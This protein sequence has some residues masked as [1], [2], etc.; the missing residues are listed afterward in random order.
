[1][2]FVAVESKRFPQND[3]DW[4]V[5]PAFECKAGLYPIIIILYTGHSEIHRH[6]CTQMDWVCA[7]VFLGETNI[8][9]PTAAVASHS[10][11]TIL[12]ADTHIS[13][14]KGMNM[15]TIMLLWCQDICNFSSLAWPTVKLGTRLVLCVTALSWTATTEARSAMRQFCWAAEQLR[16]LG[17]LWK[18]ERSDDVSEFIIWLVIVPGKCIC[19]DI[20]DPWEPLTVIFDSYL[21]DLLCMAVRYFKP[22]SWINWAVPQFRKVGFASPPFGCG[23]VGHQKKT[24]FSV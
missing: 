12:A 23:A 1:M 8:A 4:I 7:N 19:N 2:Q 6:C 16:S 3:C 17:C 22:D 14:P 18:I 24:V 5:L 10:A 11:S 15:S 20:F 21:H 13:W 9:S